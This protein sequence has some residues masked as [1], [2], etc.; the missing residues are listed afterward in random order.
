M[1]LISGDLY[2]FAQLITASKRKMSQK[3]TSG[4][5]LLAEQVQNANQFSQQVSQ[6]L[7]TAKLQVDVIEKGGGDRSQPIP[8]FL[9]KGKKQYTSKNRITKILVEE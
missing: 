1:T 3:V 5:K 8:S 4:Y 7:Q 6:A 9:R 2:V